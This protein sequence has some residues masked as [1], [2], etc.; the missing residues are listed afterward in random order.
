MGNGSIEG[1]ERKVHGRMASLFAQPYISPPYTDTVE[2]SSK[3]EILMAQQ[4]AV[5][6]YERCQ[7]G[8]ATARRAEPPQQV[9]AG[10]TRMMNSAL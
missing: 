8:N 1:S 7:Q 3:N 2:F 10:G 9:D 5:N 6:E 4:S